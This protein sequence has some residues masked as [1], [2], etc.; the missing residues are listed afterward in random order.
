MHLPIPDLLARAT[1]LIAQ[2]H[3]P[4]RPASPAAPRPSRAPST[5]PCAAPVCLALRWISPAS[6]APPPPSPPPRR[7]PPRG[8]L[9]RGLT[10]SPDETRRA[11]SRTHPRRPC[12]GPSP[13][14]RRRSPPSFAYSSSSSSSSS[15][16]AAAAAVPVNPAG[17][18]GAWAWP[19]PP[20]LR[21]P[22]P[23]AALL[24]LAFR[25]GLAAHAP[26]TPLSAPWLSAAAGMAAPPALTG[27]GA[28]SGGLM[29]ARRYGP[30]GA[31]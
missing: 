7:S 4:P 14:P 30:A 18:Y 25:V 28:P 13:F 12:E 1:V 2:E 21:G 31:Y 17:G 9:R 10:A 11:F 5:C 22:L 3:S 8:L 27:L 26:P 16:A 23:P 19:P 6:A 29:P 24:A 20:D 15:A